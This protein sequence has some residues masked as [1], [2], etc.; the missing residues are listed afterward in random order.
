MQFLCNMKDIDKNI[1][2]FREIVNIVNIRIYRAFNDADEKWCSVVIF[3]Q[4]QSTKYN[5]AKYYTKLCTYSHRM[6]LWRR[7][8]IVQPDTPFELKF[9]SWG[10]VIRKKGKE[11]CNL[12]NSSGLFAQFCRRPKIKVNINAKINSKCYIYSNNASLIVKFAL[13]SRTKSRPR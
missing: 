7:S 8:R 9:F 1:L 12:A 2:A 13:V 11:K 3:T 6:S 5:T 4:M 10:R